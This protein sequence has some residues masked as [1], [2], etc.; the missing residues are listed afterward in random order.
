[1][2]A[3][4]AE[5]E[6]PIEKFAAGGRSLARVDGF[7]VFVPWAVPGDRVRARVYKKKKAYAEAAIE[8]VLAPSALRVSPPCPYFG[9]CGGCRWQHVK[10][11]AQLDAKTDNVRDALT[12]IGQFEEVSVR[13]AIGSEKRYFYRNKMEFSFSANRWLTRAEID[14]GGRFD[15]RFALGLH[16][17]GHFDK[18]LD[19]RECH[20]QSVASY[21]MV[22]RIRDFVREK[23]WP[24]WRIRKHTGFLRHLVIRTGERTGE[25]MVNLVT[26][27]FDA[28][29]MGEMAAFLRQDSPDVT[30]FVNTIHTGKAQTAFGER[31]ETLSG[32]GVIRD[33]IGPHT[34]EIA[35]NSFFQTN[36]A[37]AERL[38]ETVRDFAELQPEDRVYDLYCGAGTISIFVADA[39]RCVTGVERIAE[40]VRDARANAEANGVK[41]CTFVQGDMP[42]AFGPDFAERYGAADVLLVDPPR[43][44]LH[45]KV[46]G[47]IGASGPERFV[48][49][50]CN[51]GTQARD[52]GLLRDAYRIEAV[53]PVDMFPHTPHVE[54]VVKLRRKA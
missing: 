47:Q 46:V 51:P 25:I 6:V 10:Y 13:P 16:V 20:L 24:P 30:T 48:Y 31:V 42:T 54:N 26:N 12:R 22:N 15:T 23:G 11:Q 21:E 40:S 2:I 39:V 3:R 45:P 7:V 9:T 14:S 17:P 27:G 4:G 38:Y 53:Q 52:L 49:V 1:M 50:S 28:E 5:I 18:V 35:P 33:R 32:P 8:E 43:A 37:Q 36:T 34:F 44:G 41:N 29:R 19:V